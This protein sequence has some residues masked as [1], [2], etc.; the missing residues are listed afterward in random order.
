MQTT[1]PTRSAFRLPT[2]HKEPIILHL[3]RSGMPRGIYLERAGTVVTIE[4]ALQEGFTVR[5]E[6]S[7]AILTLVQQF[8]ESRDRYAR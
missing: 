5:G 3:D 1:T 4:T 7:P 6:D 8:V 2:I